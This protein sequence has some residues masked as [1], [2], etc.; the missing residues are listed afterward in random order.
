MRTYM[1]NSQVM[2]MLQV[3]GPHFF[4][5]WEKKGA[6]VRARARARGKSIW[7]TWIGCLPQAPSWDQTRNLD[8]C[9]DQ[10]SNLPPFGAW[11][12]ALIN[13]AT[14]ARAQQPQHLLHRGL[15][16][17]RTV[18]SPSP[19]SRCRLYTPFVPVCLNSANGGLD[20]SYLYKVLILE[21]NA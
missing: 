3:H 19:N 13:W 21:I 6:R 12:N 18:L 14:L 8:M 2:L 20:N 9:P 5:Y 15:I 17:K 16:M 10:E 4:L 1:S 7:E 11:N